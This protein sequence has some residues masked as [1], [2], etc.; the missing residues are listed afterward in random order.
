GRVAG[1]PASCI[2]TS[3]SDRLKVIDE[4]AIVYDAGDTIWVN[5]TKNPGDLDW[6]DTLVINRLSTQQL[7]RLDQ[8]TTIDQGSGFFSGV[9]FLEDFVP[10][11]KADSS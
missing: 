3:R 5:R 8:V 10:N 6:N 2:S 1:E 7:C 11:K 4:T 9:V